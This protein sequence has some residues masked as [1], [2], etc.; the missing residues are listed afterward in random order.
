MS[1]LLTCLLRDWVHSHEE[2]TT[3]TVVYRPASYNFPPS[4]GR[5]GIEFREDG[6]LIYHGIAATDGS[7]QAAGHWELEAPN[8]VRVEVEAEGIRS[9]TLEIVSCDSAVLKVR[10]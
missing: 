5:R 6:Q 2:D 9:F 4:R 3:D 1:D 7:Q 10:R 8:R